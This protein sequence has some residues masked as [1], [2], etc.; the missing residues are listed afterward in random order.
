MCSS[1]RSDFRLSSP[2][3]MSTTQT[4][5]LPPF[6]DFD[7]VERS[8]LDVARKS[9]R[10]AGGWAQVAIYLSSRGEHRRAVA[11]L[12]EAIANC[13]NQ[14]ALLQAIA[15]LLVDVPGHADR[16]EA[17][18]RLAAVLPDD[19]GVLTNY[20]LAALHAPNPADALIPLRRAVEL[21]ESRVEVLL[22][23]ASAERQLGLTEAAV[24]LYD[25]V[26]TMV[27]SHPTA[28]VERWHCGLSTFDWV[29]ALPLEADVEAVFAKETAETVSPFMGLALPPR[30][31]LML[32]D[33]VQRG[34][35]SHLSGRGLRH[36]GAAASD[37]LRVG[38]LSSDFV[39]HATTLLT[40]GLFA[41]HDRTA[42]EIFVYSYG[43]R[44]TAEGPAHI[45]SSVEHWHDVADWDDDAIATLIRSHRLDVLVEMK[46]HTAGARPE[47]S[48]QRVAPVQ[49]HYLGCPG[50]VGGFG[51][52]YF[53]ADEVTVPSGTEAQ[54]NVPVIKLPRAYQVND[55]ER[56]LPVASSRSALGVSDDSI[57]L[58]NFNQLWKIRPEFMLVWCRA[59][60]AFPNAILWLLDAGGSN[61][62]STSINFRA[63]LNQNEF[64][65]LVDRIVFVPRLR[66]EQHMNRLAAV[67]LCLDQLPYGSHT[68]GSD[69]LWAG[70]PMLTVTGQTFAGRVGASLLTTHD[71]PS[72]IAA[73]M[74]EYETRLHELLA[75]PQLLVDARQRLLGKRS[76]SRLFDTVGFA[77]DWEKLLTK[78]NSDGRAASS[79]A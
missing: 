56:P 12:W 65:Q 14:P 27:P 18:A 57:L 39:D 70:V 64:S 19:I 30:N 63:W 45:A 79:P 59:L 66:N 20:G 55:S 71:E 22:T 44:S 3:S 5:S 23:L 50:P 10:D 49:V 47:I 16:L 4:Q 34:A 54:F 42:F 37:R 76:T 60:S 36:A 58:A 2:S 53:V 9:P 1:L 6:D 32:R 73:D 52:D 31:P 29:G 17:L 38:Y 78:L 61:Q 35:K 25:R 67:D 26:L 15:D 33:F 40:R 43:A 28:V 75:S 48:R 68:T 69:A 77:R 13:G 24:R 51:I 7:R 74:Q 21:G 72:F 8:L 11:V 62:A 41:A 46:G